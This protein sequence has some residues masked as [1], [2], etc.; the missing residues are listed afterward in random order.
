MNSKKLA[1]PYFAWMFI[2]TIIPIA[3]IAYFAFTNESGEFSLEAIGKISS[4]SSTIIYSIIIALIST[5]ICL[6]LA[7]PLSYIMS[8]KKFNVQKTLVILITLPMWLN[9]LLRIYSWII[10]LQKGG[11]LDR[12]VN[13]FGTDISL[14][15]NSGAVVLGMVYNFLPF[16]ILP[17]YTAMSKIDNSILEAASD[18]GGNGRQIFSKVI[19][20]LSVPGIVSGITMVFVPAASTFLV[21]QYLGGTNNLMIGDIIEREFLRSKNVGSAISLVLMVVMLLFM[22]VM[23]KFSD[24]NMEGVI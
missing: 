19:F 13:I 9:F 10:L 4:Y 8:R 14:L 15:G 22:T 7:Y 23:N 6:L 17:L 2:F 20:P 21:S 11:I 24:D 18:L 12:I 3:M 16:M 5:V 1:F